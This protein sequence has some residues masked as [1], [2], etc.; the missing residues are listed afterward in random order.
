MKNLFV[1]IDISKDVFDYCFLNEKNEVLSKGQNQNT[2][3][4]ISKFCKKLKQYRS[5]T[6]WICMEHT[7]YY[8][9][10]LASEF[11]KQ[12]FT[13]S[14]LDPLDLKYSMGMLRGKND[15]I[16]AFRIA[17]YGLSHNHKLK[18]HSLPSKQLQQL[19]VLMKARERYNKIR[20]QLKNA[21]KGLKVAGTTI[22]LEE[23]V[24]DNEDLIDK[25]EEKIKALDKRMKTIINSTD[26]LK[27]T[28]E[29]IVTVVGVGPVTATKCIIETGNFNKIT[30][31]RKFCCHSGLAPFTY[32]SG[33]SVKGK[34]KTSPLCNKSLK[35]VLYKAAWSAI[36]H[37]PQLKRY[38]RRKREEGKH[39]LSVANAVANK[40]VL[41]IF[42]VQKREEPYVKLAA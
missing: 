13:Y 29:K 42:A 30:D 39:K 41:R 8:G 4:G 6:P 23:L 12:G 27:K 37:D 15:S 1:G 7:G 17:S 2:K 20:V 25:M 26:E 28:Y 36:Q 32:E 31:P 5:Y 3:D 14:L 9:Y 22:D 34:T 40:V 35:A 21:L 10:L 33:S 16:D 19:K 24:I 11:N 38:H 18:P